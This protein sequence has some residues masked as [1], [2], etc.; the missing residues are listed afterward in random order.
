LALRFPGWS[1][2]SKRK[3]RA[4]PKRLGGASED[5]ACRESHG[6]GGF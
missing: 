6:G 5:C 3:P 1:R 4:A 2:K